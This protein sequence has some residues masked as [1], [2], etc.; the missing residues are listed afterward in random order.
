MEPQRLPR[1]IPYRHLG[2]KLDDAAPFKWAIINGERVTATQGSM[3]Q[4]EQSRLM[5]LLVLMRAVRDFVGGQKQIDKWVNVS[6]G[7]SHITRDLNPIYIMGRLKDGKGGTWTTDP[8][9]KHYSIEGYALR[10]FQKLCLN[11]DNIDH[12]AG[13]PAVLTDL[14]DV[15]IVNGKVVVGADYTLP[16]EPTKYVKTIAAE[17]PVVGSPVA[18]LTDRQQRLLAA[19]THAHQHSSD[20][21]AHPEVDHAPVQALLSELEVVAEDE[22]KRHVLQ[23]MQFNGGHDERWSDDD[24]AAIGKLE[25]VTWNQWA[26]E[27]N[28]SVPNWGFSRYWEI[29]HQNAHIL[30]A[31]NTIENHDDVQMLYRFPTLD[32][33]GH[34]RPYKDCLEETQLQ[35]MTRLRAGLVLQVI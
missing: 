35:V 17:G 3:D 16:S 24:V 29:A 14:L 34:A 18:P 23:L 10:A 20:P 2:C 33:A 1:P 30:S 6:S 11:K 7:V 8:T 31:F 9:G 15:R 22:K 5:A 28:R 32:H 27:L 13:L 21:I 25:D 4:I 19:A 26:I 12:V